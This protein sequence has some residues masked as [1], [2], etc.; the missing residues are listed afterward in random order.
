MEQKRG[1]IKIK[2]YEENMQDCMQKD[3]FKSDVAI[4]K[5]TT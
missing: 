2:I 3:C 5:L 4:S 1:I